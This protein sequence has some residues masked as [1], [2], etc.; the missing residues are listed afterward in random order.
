MRLEWPE[1]TALCGVASSVYT[2]LKD[3]KLPQ[4]STVAIHAEGGRAQLACTM[5]CAMGY[6]VIMIGRDRHSVMPSSQST[7]G[8]P[9]S[10]SNNGS[11]SA[12]D[13]MTRSACFMPMTKNAGQDLMKHHGGACAILCLMPGVEHAQSMIEG[14]KPNGHIVLFAPAREDNLAIPTI[15]LIS[16]RRSVC[17]FP[18]ST[19]LELEKCFELV[20]MHSECFKQVIKVDK[21]KVED[22]QKA[23]EAAMD[24]NAKSKPILC[25][26]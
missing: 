8:T 5:A 12:L 22:A 2:C 13:M 16:D 10:S 17:G 20:K 25:M 6:R 23:F 24:M 3:L 14:L 15:P 21:Y 1:M 9:S 26:D 11:S 4:A 19:P 7:N 18:S